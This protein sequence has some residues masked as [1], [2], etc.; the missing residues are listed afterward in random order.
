[1][2]T[3]YSTTKDFGASS[4]GKTAA[5]NSHAL[6]SLKQRLRLGAHLLDRA[7]SSQYTSLPH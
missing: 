2:R 1:M 4:R 5:R 6:E 3:N 7:L